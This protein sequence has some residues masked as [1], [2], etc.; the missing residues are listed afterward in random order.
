MKKRYFTAISLLCGYKRRKSLV[1]VG[2]F[3]F[4]V[5][6]NAYTMANPYASTMQKRSNIPGE[7]TQQKMK[8]INPYE[9]SSNSMNKSMVLPSTKDNKNQYMQKK[10]SESVPYD[11]VPY[12]GATTQEKQVIVHPDI[13]HPDIVT[14]ATVA[15]L[16]AKTKV[17]AKKASKKEHDISH[18]FSLFASKE[19][20]E[21]PEIARIIKD[22]EVAI[23]KLEQDLIEKESKLQGIA[24]QKL[25][26]L[27]EKIEQEVLA[28]RQRAEK[29]AMDLKEDI[30]SE[31]LRLRQEA[32]HKTFGIVSQAEE[33]AFSLKRQA[34][35]KEFEDRFCKSV[36]SKPSRYSKK[37][38]EIKHRFSEKT[39]ATDPSSV[40]IVTGDRITPEWK[41]DVSRQFYSDITYMKK[42]I[43]D[44]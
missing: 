35:I 5:S 27:K 42:I 14:T 6:S 7:M 43:L 12:M 10:K 4:I 31:A 38:R 36:E 34:R 2:F 39:V 41:N 21:S 18:E 30:Q 16:E 33:E 25:D 9:R 28:M 11:K 19:S 17:I 37:P 13:V 40:D 22:S 32:V 44:G 1:V 3:I 29:I 15:P 24:E 26:G 23:Q 8:V 20:F